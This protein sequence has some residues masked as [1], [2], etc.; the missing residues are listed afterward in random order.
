MT[1]ISNSL[2]RLLHHEAAGGIILLAAAMLAIVVANSPLN[3]LYDALLETP[4]G[5]RIGAFELNK[6]LLLWINDGLM[7]IFFFFVGLEIK[8]EALTGALSSLDRAILPAIAALGGMVVPALI[9]A[10]INFGNP[11]ALR[12]WAIPSATDIAFAVGVLTLLGPRVPAA[13]KVFLLAL[14]ILDDLGAI[15]IIA[16][17][18]TSNLSL[19]ALGL[20]AA[21]CMMLAVLNRQGVTQP[22]PYLLVGLLIWVC[23][24]KSG[25]HA[26]LAGVV[27]ALA[28][29]LAPNDPHRRSLLETLEQSLH[30]WVVFGILPM[31]AFANA[32][33]AL[34]GLTVG[35]LLT[36]IPLGIAAGLFVGKSVG[37]A[38]A[39]WLAVASGIARLPDGTTWAQVRAVAVL[40]GIGFTM[41]LFIGM[42]ALPEPQYATPMRVGVLA[43]SLASAV[44]GYALMRA[45]TRPASF[46]AHYVAPRKRV[47]LD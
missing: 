17:F 46:S 35:Q 34:T 40:G 25:V 44:V 6:P 37:I 45:A 47:D 14:A 21:G 12:G 36:P 4:A 1:D 13:L 5:V 31:F 38:G 24:L 26:T 2:R 29:P 15:I 11:A 22:A 32:G 41:S 30:P 27:T 16:L 43:G 18:Y 42:L 39:V 28:I 7:A 23:V 8:K 20:A 33:V 9:Y 3:W 10:A 19:L